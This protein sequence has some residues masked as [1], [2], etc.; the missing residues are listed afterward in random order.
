MKRV[1]DKQ[2][3][4]YSA[5]TAGTPGLCVK[6]PNCRGLAV[7][8][9]DK[10]NARFK[11]T[12]CGNFKEKSLTIFRYDVHNQ[13]RVCGRYYRI[14]ITGEEKQHFQTLHT[15]CPYCGTVMSGS[16]QKIAKGVYAGGEIRNGCEPYFGYELWFLAYFDNKPVWAVNREHL[17]YLIEY[18]CADLR[19][20]PACYKYTS[21][22]TQADHL[23]AFMKTAKNRERIVKLLKNMQKNLT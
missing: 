10:D 23:P 4:T 5:Y 20:R 12:N 19:E 21:T 14:D 6:C 7:V 16:V 22:K 2:Y 8:T 3:F 11:C 15:A 9:A 13:C 17:A 1:K 18:L